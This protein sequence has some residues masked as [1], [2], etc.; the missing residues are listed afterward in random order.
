MCEDDYYDYDDDYY[1]DEEY[2][3]EDEDEHYKEQE[4]LRKEQEEARQRAAAARLAPKPLVKKPVAAKKATGI[5][6]S[7]KSVAAGTDLTSKEEAEKTRLVTSMGFSAELANEALRKYDLD[8]QRAINFLLSNPGA[9]AAAM[10][11]APPKANTMSPPPGLTKPKSQMMAPPPGMKPP[12][13]V[14]QKSEKSKQQQVEKNESSKISSA[15]KTNGKATTTSATVEHKIEVP[16][17]SSMKKISPEMKKRL[18]NQKSRLTMVILGH[19]DAGKSTLMGNVLVQT[20]MVQQRTVAKYQKQAGEIG[21]ASFALAWI[22]DEDESERERGVTIDIATKHIS[23]DKHDVTI[24]DAPGH[25]DYV[26][27]MIT[28]AGVSDVGILVVS[29][30]RG[31]FE[32]GFD[33]ATGTGGHKGHVGQTREHVTL[34]RGLG[35]SQLIVAVNK[36]DAAEPAWSKNRFDEIKTRLTPYLKQNGF[37][38]KRVQFVPISGLTGINIKEKPLKDAPALSK[39]Y[40][41]KTLL[42]AIN[43]FEPAKRNIEKPFRFIVSD[44]Y[45]EGKGITIKGRVAQGLVSAGDKVAVLPVS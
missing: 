26:P 7:K 1:D 2:W 28:G 31:E 18:K 17:V 41:G 6:I 22:M 27:A 3:E 35:V 34:A 40:T 29:S 20:G 19:V 23:T 43:G 45:S 4:R 10:T 14:E 38:M 36:L 33:A 37:D 21:K 16:G 11:M 15:K 32:S 13:S 8:P 5:S 25:A 42:Q 12:A 44:L 9:G 39:W 24:L 30:T